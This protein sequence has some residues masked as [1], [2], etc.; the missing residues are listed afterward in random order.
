MERQL[1]EHHEAVEKCRALFFTEVSKWQDRRDELGRKLIDD[2]FTAAGIPGH[3]KKEAIHDLA[4]QIPDSSVDDDIV[5]QMQFVKAVNEIARL[6]DPM[7]V[8]P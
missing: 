4:I 3:P 8:V 7:P 1:R 6:F 2:A 5:F